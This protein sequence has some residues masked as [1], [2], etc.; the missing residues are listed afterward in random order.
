MST[1]RPK[2]RRLPA[3][4]W[5]CMPTV[6]GLIGGGVVRLEHGSMLSAL[7]IAV[8][9][10]A[11]SLLLCILFAIGYLAA[12]F[13]YVR[14][15]AGER[16]AMERLIT[17]SANAVVSILTLSKSPLAPKDEGKPVVP[18]PRSTP[19]DDA[20]LTEERRSS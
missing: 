9:P 18:P 12:V 3:Y 11:I 17:L 19:S 13:R 8:A 4:G 16:D 5:L 20:R 7:V 10:F 6:G 15:E 1:H 14:A 2:S